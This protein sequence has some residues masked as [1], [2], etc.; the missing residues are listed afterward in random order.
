[1]IDKCNFIHPATNP[2]FGDIS[3]RKRSRSEAGNE[4]EKIKKKGKIEPE[5]KW[6]YVVVRESSSRVPEPTPATSPQQTRSKR[7]RGRGKSRGRG[8]TEEREEKMKFRVNVKYAR[9]IVGVYA[10]LKGANAKVEKFR[11]YIVVE[12]GGFSLEEEDGRKWME[13]K[14]E[15]GKIWLLGLRRRMLRGRRKTMRTLS[16]TNMMKTKYRFAQPR[17]GRD[18]R[19]K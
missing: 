11:E 17:V 8:G 18:S 3:S 15:E 5:L 4:D 7:G 13:W 9:E 6:V 14:G 10:T 12:K 19:I 16:R 2:G 1:M